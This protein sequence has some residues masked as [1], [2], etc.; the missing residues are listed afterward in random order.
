M[1]LPKP[2]TR[3]KFPETP[4]G[5]EQY[6]EAIGYWRS[7]VGRIKAM[8]DLANRTARSADSPASPAPADSPQEP[9]AP[10]TK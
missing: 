1:A 7:S 3:D 6:E 9:S 2:P 10:R 8:V 4:E 5:Q